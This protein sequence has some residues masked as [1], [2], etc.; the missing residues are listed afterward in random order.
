MKQEKNIRKRSDRRW[1]NRRQKDMPVP[2]D[3]RSNFDRRTG[4][5]RRLKFQKK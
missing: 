4:I 2:I 1:E 3:R 5:D